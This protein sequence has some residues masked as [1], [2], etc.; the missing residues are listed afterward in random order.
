MCTR[1]FPDR[2][3]RSFWRL[4][5]S[6]VFT[7][8]APRLPVERWGERAVLLRAPCVRHEPVP[9]RALGLWVAPGQTM[10][11]Q[12]NEVV[13]IKKEAAAHEKSAE[14]L[15]LRLNG[16][17]GSISPQHIEAAGGHRALVALLHGPLPTAERAAVCIAWLVFSHADSRDAVRRAGGIPPLV[18]LLNEAATA[19]KAAAALSNM[20]YSNSKN[21]DAIRDAGGIVPLLRVM[22]ENT[23]S[24]AAEKAVSALYSL[25]LNER[26]QEAIRKAGGIPPLV[27]LVSEGARSKVAGNS[28]GA[29]S[30][31]ALNDTNQDAIRRAQGIQP[32]VNLL[33]ELLAAG[34]DSRVM[35]NAACALANLAYSNT[36]NQQAVADAGGILPLV[37]LLQ[38]GADSKAAKCAADAL[39][40]LALNTACQKDLLAAVARL[41]NGPPLQFPRLMRRLQAL[42]EVGGSRNL[43]QSS[44]GAST[45]QLQGAGRHRLGGAALPSIPARPTAGVEVHAQP[46]T[47]ERVDANGGAQTPHRYAPARPNASPNGTNHSRPSPS[48][49]SSAAPTPHM[50]PARMTCRSTHD[51]SPRRPLLAQSSEKAMRAACEV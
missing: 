46:R 28:A 43:R 21:Q 38:A 4:H 37:T 49:R 20:A 19:E 32:L 25:A 39:C 33:T 24:K 51:Q 41:P 31:L 11:G 30:S 9:T 15:V 48:S 13:F 2:R 29:L 40:H 35:G 27:A 18:A 17:R 1:A 22:M 5:Q 8:G 23:G 16:L 44:S 50:T 3:P 7:K 34:A 26:N 42:S 47:V 45:R 36:A 6:N 12:Q 10:S 14:K